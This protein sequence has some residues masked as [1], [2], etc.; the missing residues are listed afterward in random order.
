M[1]AV[2]Y[3][4]NRSQPLWMAEFINWPLRSKGTWTRHFLFSG[5]VQFEDIEW[6]HWLNVTYLQCCAIAIPLDKTKQKNNSGQSTASICRP[7]SGCELHTKRLW[8]LCFDSQ[9]PGSSSTSAARA[10]K[11]T[12]RWE[13]G[14][15]SPIPSRRATWRECCWRPSTSRAG[16]APK[17]VLSVT[18]M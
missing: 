16:R 3:G 4:A 11:E 6:C 18:G 7:A 12:A 1:L 10:P 5:E 17:G 2:T 14:S 8:P 13:V 9:I 15:T